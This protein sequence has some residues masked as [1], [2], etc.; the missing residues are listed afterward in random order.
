MQGVDFPA[1]W[2]GLE[3]SE[4]EFEERMVTREKPTNEQARVKSVP[5][6]ETHV[7]IRDFVSAHR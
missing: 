7:K 1:D 5:K 6:K 3:L 2:K 4:D